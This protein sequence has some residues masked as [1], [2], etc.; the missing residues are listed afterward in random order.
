MTSTDACAAAGLPGEAPRRPDTERSQKALE[1]AAVSFVSPC[2]PLTLERWPSWRT[3]YCCVSSDHDHLG[4]GYLGI[5]ELSSSCS[6]HQSLLQLNIRPSRRCDC[7]RISTHRLLPSRLLLQSH[8]V[9]CPYCDC[10]GILDSVCSLCVDRHNCWDID[11]LGLGSCVSI[12]CNPPL[13]N[14]SPSHSYTF[15]LCLGIS[16][17]SNNRWVKTLL[18]HRYDEFWDLCVFYFVICYTHRGW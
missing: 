1:A 8:S 7:G 12:Y 3:S 5:Q 14:T 16:M 9:R 2:R 10:G 13:C 15:E 6:T 4:L 17:V 11:P 18:G